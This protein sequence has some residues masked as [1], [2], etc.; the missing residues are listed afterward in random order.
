MFKKLVLA[1]TILISILLFFPNLFAS[2]NN[3]SS[4]EQLELKEYIIENGFED[5]LSFKNKDDIN[6]N[7]KE[8]FNVS[9]NKD[10]NYDID[11][12]ENLLKIKKNWNSLNDK[13]KENIT[14]ELNRFYDSVS[15][16]NNSKY[17]SFIYKE[18]PS[19]FLF[20]WL[21]VYFLYRR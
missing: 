17:V 19:F 7:D 13:R 15:K 6:K 21:L 2:F 10:D 1:I 18:L 8:L 5:I 20:G 3:Y 4:K 11:T 12:K 9:K 14:K 16:E